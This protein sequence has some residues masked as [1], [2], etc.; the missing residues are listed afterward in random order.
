M[1]DGVCGT[2]PSFA[3]FKDYSTIAYLLKLCSRAARIR[4]IEQAKR[5]KVTSEPTMAHDSGGCPQRVSFLGKAV[6]YPKQ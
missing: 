6:D 2:S 1:Y 4:F 3:C 5:N